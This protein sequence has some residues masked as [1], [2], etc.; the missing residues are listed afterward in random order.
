[1]TNQIKTFQVEAH[2][3]ELQEFNYKKPKYGFG[4]RLNLRDSKCVVKFIKFENYAYKY[5]VMAES[6]W[7]GVNNGWR[8]EEDYLRR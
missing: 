2:E 5:D 4:E 1:M 6:Y 8:V 7:G 3:R